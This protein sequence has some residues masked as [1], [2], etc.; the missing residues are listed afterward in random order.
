METK[1]VNSDHLPYNFIY[2]RYL[3]LYGSSLEFVF[4]REW[5]RTTK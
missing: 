1:S 5:L 3:G 4:V 2:H